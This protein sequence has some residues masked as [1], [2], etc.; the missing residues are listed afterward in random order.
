MCLSLPLVML[1]GLWRRCDYEVKLKEKL[2]QAQV[3]NRWRKRVQVALNPWLQ[4]QRP[5]FL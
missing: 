4:T 2:S 5:W 3:R 1:S